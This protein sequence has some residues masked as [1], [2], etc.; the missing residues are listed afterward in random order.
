MKT[1]KQLEFSYKMT[2]TG[3]VAIT[4]IV[5]AVLATSS[6]K[7]KECSGTQPVDERLTDSVYYPTENDVM[8]LDT[9]LNQVQD[10]EKDLDTLHIRM[11]RIED[12]IDDMLEEQKTGWHGREGRSEYGEYEAYSEWMEMQ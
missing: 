6:N 11:D 4:I 1:K 7:L 2:A 8:V 5:I 9:M 3:I 12:K 10:I